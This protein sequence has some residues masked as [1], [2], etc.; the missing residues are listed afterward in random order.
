MLCLLLVCLLLA[1]CF[2]SFASLLLRLALLAVGVA[3]VRTSVWGWL[4]GAALV[5]CAAVD[6]LFLLFRIL[7]G[8]DE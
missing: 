6:A 2:P 8:D 7:G 1:F 5:L 4:P 3:L